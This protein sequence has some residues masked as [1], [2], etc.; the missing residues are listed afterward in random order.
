MVTKAFAASSRRVSALERDPAGMPS[1]EAAFSCGWG[2]SMR[3]VASA[4]GSRVRRG[5][6]E[7]RG[8]SASCRAVRNSLLS[9]SSSI[10]YPIVTH[11]S[12]QDRWRGRGVGGEDLRTYPGVEG[13]GLDRTICLQRN[14]PTSPP[15]LNT[16]SLR[17]KGRCESP[18]NSTPSQATGA[19]Y[20]GPL[21]VQHCRPLAV[22]ARLQPN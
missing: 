19:V 15:A 6:A 11:M 8:T 22:V 4:S 17:K 13:E 7:G 2:C 10:A 20:L 21:W 18:S 12:A 1:S 14:A 9:G 3:R 16:A 5:S